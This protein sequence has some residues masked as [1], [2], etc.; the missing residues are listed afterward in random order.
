MTIS[1]KLV[2]TITDI[3]STCNELTEERK[4]KTKVQNLLL[5]REVEGEAEP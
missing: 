5:E 2:T 3:V 1:P 4:K